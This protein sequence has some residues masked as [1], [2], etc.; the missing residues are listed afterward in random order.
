MRVLL[1]EDNPDNALLTRS[2]LAGPRSPWIVEHTD[3]L[4][5]ALAFLKEHGADVILLDLQLP[6]ARGLEAV[7]RLCSAFPTVPVVVMTSHH[8]EAMGVVAL[9]KGAQDYLVKTQMDKNGLDRSLR[10]AIER[11]RAVL[12]G[13]LYAS[14]FESS[15]DPIV[16]LDA[17][18]RVTGWSPAATRAYGFDADDMIGQPF[19]VLAAEGTVDELDAL[20]TRA[21]EGE[22]VAGVLSPQVRKDFS[23]FPVLLT[24]GLLKGPTGRTLGAT[25]LVQVLAT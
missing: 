13:A 20:V 10:Y 22:P 19:T 1:V 25:V 18:G 4:Q 16:T 3:T 14:V 8:D 5:G 9:Q 11:I 17:G 7:N 2:R 15:R 6:D 24:L 23:A 12:T 21:L